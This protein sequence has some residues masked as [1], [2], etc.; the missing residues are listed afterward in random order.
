[1]PDSTET[2]TDTASLTDLPAEAAGVVAGDDVT[3]VC[4]AG[5]LPAVVLHTL[6]GASAGLLVEHPRSP[7]P[8]H[9]TA[10]YDARGV[11]PGT[12]HLPRCGVAVT[13]MYAESRPRLHDIL[14]RRAE[15]LRERANRLDSLSC[16]L[17]DVDLDG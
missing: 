14:R 4:G 7:H 3:Y 9:V 13:A 11:E 10:R 16:V 2:V 1:M 5:H 17:R 6:A 8:I 15:E 12:W